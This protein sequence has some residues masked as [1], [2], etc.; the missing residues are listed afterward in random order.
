[1][2]ETR[3]IA[4]TDIL[5]DPNQPRKI[6]D[7]INLWE[8]ANSIERQGLLQPILVKPIDGNKFQIISGERRFRAC[9]MLGFEKIRA[10]IKELDDSEILEIQLIEN[11]Q[12]EDLSPLEEAQTYK[13]MIDEFGY[14]HEE[15]ADKIFKSREYIT[16]KLRLLKLDDS[17]KEALLQGRV[18]EG[19]ARPLVSLGEDSQRE[20][21][22]RITTEDL[23]VRQV[24]EE[25]KSRGIVSRETSD[26]IEED[27]L[28]V[29]IWLKTATYSAVQETARSKKM[30]PEK[31]CANIVEEEMNL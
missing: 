2:N 12:R 23:S 15:I 6:F 11:L 21:L 17:V 9:K 13:R 18:S 10:E 19:H 31:L 5:S 14:T 3:E 4:L 25:V 16:N 29:G 24:E 22:Q 8:L 20:L 26:P 30:T 1:M 7:E 28:V 27:G